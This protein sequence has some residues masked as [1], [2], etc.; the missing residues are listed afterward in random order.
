MHISEITPIKFMLAMFQSS[1]DFSE[2]WDLLVKAKIWYEHHKGIKPSSLPEST[3]Y[4]YREIFI[5]F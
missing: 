5:K 1:F 2:E 4:E 3:L